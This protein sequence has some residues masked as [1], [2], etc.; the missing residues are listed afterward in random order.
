VKRDLL[1]HPRAAP[2]PAQVGSSCSGLSLGD[3]TALGKVHV[4]AMG[5]CHRVSMAERSP[6]SSKGLHAVPTC[7]PTN[8][9]AASGAV[10]PG[11]QPAPE[12]GC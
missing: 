8:T 5:R 2:V 10:G 9:P 4:C 3:S 6:A 7:N 11:P 1:L 12:A